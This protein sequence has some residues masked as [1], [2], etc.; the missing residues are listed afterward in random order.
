MK[1][2]AEARS[3]WE[4]QSEGMVD[5]SHFECTQALKFVDLGQPTVCRNKPISLKDQVICLPH[6]RHDLFILSCA[7]RK[8]VVSKA[9]GIASIVDDR[10]VQHRLHHSLGLQAVTHMHSCI[11]LPC[12]RCVF[13]GN[14]SKTKLVPTLFRSLLQIA[15]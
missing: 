7:A 10:G 13:W 1:Q 11:Q 2:R 9:C 6:C 5:S 4:G 8:M 12:V 3:A 15:C 14:S